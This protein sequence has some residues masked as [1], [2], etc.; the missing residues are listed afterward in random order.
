[1]KQEPLVKEVTVNAPAAKVWKALTDNKE[2]KNWYFDIKEFKPVVG[3]EFTFE[4]G[5]DDKV[6]VHLC[7][8]TD[9]IKNK[10]LSYSWKYK[11]YPG[12]S[13]VTFE[14]FEEGNKTRLKL[15]HEGIE[16]FPQD[17]PDFARE[18]FSDG[19]DYII[20]KSIKEYLEK[21]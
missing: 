15:T 20:G 12:N 11:D 4:G 16:S 1:M 3:F 8:I 18:S 9:L 21:D 17:L 14:L 6:Y 7:K 10:K 19:W 2:M 5:K 13:L